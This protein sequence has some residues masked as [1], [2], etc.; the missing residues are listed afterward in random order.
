VV[1]VEYPPEQVGP[2]ERAVVALVQLAALE[3]P[4]LQTQ[5]VEVVVKEV[6]LAE[7]LQVLAVRAS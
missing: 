6:E 2:V 4:E 3:L 7:F 1:V 5:V